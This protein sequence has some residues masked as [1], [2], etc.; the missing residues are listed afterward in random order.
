[1]GGDDLGFGSF[2]LSSRSSHG[3]RKYGLICLVVT[4]VFCIACLFVSVLFT[5]RFGFD[6]GVQGESLVVKRVHPGSQNTH[7][8]Q[9]GDV[10]ES[11]SGKPVHTRAAFYRLMRFEGKDAILTVKRTGTRFQRP[12]SASEFAHGALPAG[13]QINDKPVMIADESG[14]YSPLENVDFQTL[15]AILENRS[16][17]VSV[18]F[19]RQEEVLSPNV[20]ALSGFSRSVGA[21]LIL[22]LVVLM[23]CIVWRDNWKPGNKHAVPVILTLGCGTIGLMTIGL[24]TVLMNFPIIFMLGIIGLTL[25]KVIDFDY[26]LTHFGNH[27]KIETW[28]RIALFVGPLATLLIPIWLCVRAMP[29]LWGVDIDPEIELKLEAFVILPMLWV[30]IYTFIDGGVTFVRRYRHAN[31]ESTPIAF[32]VGF[33]CL[34]SIFVFALLRS[35]LQAAQWFLM[36]VILAQILGNVVPML[37][38]SQQT[39]PIRLDSPEFS[40]S[41][42]REILNHAHELFGDSWLVQVVIDRPSPKHVV[43]LMRSTDDDNISGLELNVLMDSWRDFL[44]LMRVEGSCINGENHEPDPRD[45]VAG[46]AA[47]LGIVLAMPIADNVAGT[48]TSLTLIVSALRDRDDNAVPA[49]ALSAEQQSQISAIIDDLTQCAPAMVYLSAEMSLDY[50]GDDLDEIARQVHETASF[51]RAL[52]NPTIPLAAQELPHGLLDEDEEHDRDHDDASLVVNNPETSVDEYETKVYEDEVSFLKSQVQALYSQQMREYALTEIEFTKAQSDILDDM[53]TLDPPMLFVGEIGSGKQLLAMAAHQNRSSGP[54]LVMDAAQV[55]ESIFALDI[56][57]ENDTPGMIDNAA[58][59]SLY[60]QNIDR[61]SESMIRDV[62]NEINARTGRH[63]V[64]LYASVNVLPT[65]FSV[66]KYRIDPFT[67][68]RRLM[69][70]TSLLD[71]EIVVVD[72]LRDQEDIDIVAEFFR[73]KQATCANKSVDGFTPEAMLAL[74]SYAWPGNFAELRSVVERAV[75]RSEHAKLTVADLGRDFV[76]LADASTKNIAIDGTD[77]FRD[78]VQMMQALNETLQAQIERLTARNHELENQ[79]NSPPTAQSDD[80]H[81]LDGT[82]A[83]IE[84][85]LLTKLLNK[86]QNDP[87]KTAEALNLNRARLYSKLDKY[88]LIDHA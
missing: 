42:I 3:N 10:I 50:V 22:L 39:H 34:F 24:W 79:K 45:P 46:I 31:D 8:L 4:A 23:A 2:M 16:G 77:V 43:G 28:A 70:L 85:R 38:R 65:E 18:I 48:L 5:P 11:I 78:Q 82:F 55:P 41:Q 7:E 14:N 84:K 71:A 72:P 67:L 6:V 30:V 32:G 49:L 63:A 12:V 74:K 66:A 56:F 51:A 36:A 29:V 60:I 9:P 21:S 47:K 13:L 54:W 53:Q 76:D 52:K 1:M 33:G 59:G 68:P 25:F 57:G 64:A 62:M 88:Q 73:Q 44:D 40:S 86:Y 58:G 27:R 80:P 26:H 75:M 17:A 83:D 35:D 37:A 81:F 69:N 87:D 20:Q 61:L 19:K 15:R